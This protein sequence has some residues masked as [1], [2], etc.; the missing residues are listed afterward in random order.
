MSLLDL[1]ASNLGQE[2]VAHAHTHHQLILAT[3]GVTEL[4]IEGIG[5]RVTGGR[6][7]LI[8]CASHHEYEGDGRN[9]TLVLDVPLAALDGMRDGEDLQRLFER[10]RFFPVSTRLNH[11]AVTLMAQLEQFPALHSEIAALLL[12]ALYLQLKDEAPSTAPFGRHASERIDL[13]S[14][15]VWI[16]RHLADEIR[17]DQLAALCALSPGHFHALFRELTDATPL[18]YV[19]QRRLEHARAL[20]RHSRLSLG[21]IASLVGFCDQG[22][23]SRAYRRHFEVSPSSERRHC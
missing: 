15:D 2:H 8:P 4:D 20:V 7:C 18:A 5:D 1:R 11:L 16:D 9:R 23:F 21:H 19:Q 12:R 3:C 10:P 14:L 17:V 13:D 22:S 6:G